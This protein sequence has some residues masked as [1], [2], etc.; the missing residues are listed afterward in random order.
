MTFAE[1]R[2]SCAPGPVS[3]RSTRV[4]ESPL[5]VTW[6]VT[7]T[8]SPGQAVSLSADRLTLRHPPD[9]TNDTERARTTNNRKALNE[10]Y[11]LIVRTFAKPL[12]PCILPETDRA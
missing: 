10:D 12:L 2:F 3:V 4:A 5:F 11:D 7:V 9:W 8:T 1:T 6:A